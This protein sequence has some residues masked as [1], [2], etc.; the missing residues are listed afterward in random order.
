MLSLHVM[1]HVSMTSACSSL[2]DYAVISNNN[3]LN[4]RLGLCSK[5]PPLALTHARRHM[6]HCLT[7]VA[8]TRWSSSSQAVRIG[9][10]SLPTLSWVELRRR[11]V[12][13]DE[14][15][16]HSTGRRRADCMNAAQISTQLSPLNLLSLLN[17]SLKQISLHE[18]NAFSI[19]VYLLEWPIS[20][21]TTVIGPWW[22]HT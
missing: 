2:V 7:A 13:S 16:L 21:T 19:W 6:R 15:Q 8:I 18:T 9:E 4:Y 10:H 20:K 11:G 3:I 14:T 17:S 5:C 22:H 1:C 12:Q